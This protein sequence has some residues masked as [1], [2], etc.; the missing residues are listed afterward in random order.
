[1]P[2]ISH[3]NK[4]WVRC[5]CFKLLRLRGRQHVR[6]RGGLKK[7]PSVG[8]AA[9]D[10]ALRIVLPGEVHRFGLTKANSV[11]KCHQRTQATHQHG[12]PTPGPGKIRNPKN[13]FHS[14]ATRWDRIASTGNKKLFSVKP[15]Q[16]SCWEPRPGACWE[17]CQE[18]FWKP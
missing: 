14:Q 12:P 5:F 10:L 7:G 3:S 2:Y 17:A 18:A 8:W 9:D 4:N 6:Q 15:C 11:K 16:E 1:M 13:I